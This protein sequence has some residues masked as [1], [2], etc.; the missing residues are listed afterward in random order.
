MPKYT[1]SGVSPDEKQLSQILGRIAR[2]LKVAVLRVRDTQMYYDTYGFE[3]LNLMLSEVGDSFDPEGNHYA[4]GCKKILSEEGQTK[5]VEVD[6]MFFLFLG[7]YEAA[8]LEKKVAGF[9]IS[10]HNALDEANK[11][12]IY[13][14]TDRFNKVHAIAKTGE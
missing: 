9:E 3:Q 1:I 12:K 8:Q 14:G 2:N 6:E 13:N 11:V 5:S 7:S 4:I 10:A